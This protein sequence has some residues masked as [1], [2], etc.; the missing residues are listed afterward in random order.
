M[1]VNINHKNKVFS[2]GE[3]TVIGFESL[4]RR[5]YRELY[6]YAYGFVMDEMEAEDIVQET[7]S[8]LWEKRERL[9]EEIEHIQ[10]YLYASV[11]Y[12]CLR[13]FRRLKV[14][15]L[16]KKRQIEAL[17][18]SFGEDVRE[19]DEIVLAVKK[20]MHAL[21]EQQ[22]K[23]VKMHINEGLTYIEIARQLGLTDNTV[24]THIKRAYRILRKHLGCFFPGIFVF[25][26]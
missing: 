9:P 2:P 15:D 1:I 22:A 3:S 23:I 11:K 20:A 19:E 17:L 4:F 21:S 16:Y 12:A 18:L 24:R 25:F 13:Y 26:N 8:L 6:L 7:F 5:Y 10:A 14:T